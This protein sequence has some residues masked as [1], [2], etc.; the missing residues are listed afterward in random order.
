LCSQ[1]QRYGRSN[2]YLHEL[3]GISLTRDLNPK[4]YLYRWSRW[5]LKE[6]PKA[7]KNTVMGSGDLIDQI[8]DTP[9]SLVCGRARSQGQR[10]AQLPEAART[11]VYL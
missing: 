1:W 10:Q 2:R 5:L 4:D 8:I 3:H 11:I 9:V 7:A 6:I